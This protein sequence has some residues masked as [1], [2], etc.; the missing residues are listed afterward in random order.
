MNLIYITRNDRQKLIDLLHAK[1]SLDDNDQ[2]LLSELTRAEIVESKAIPG[3]VVTM[4]SLVVFS[5]IETSKTYEYWLVFPS[6]VDL[7][8]N[9]ISALS[10]VGCALLGSKIGAIISFK[11]PAGQKKL[12]VEKILHQPE[13]AGHYE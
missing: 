7:N 10:P 5:D 12:R 9:K 13:A 3:D 8:Q 6:A 1:V 11:T 4:N 2:A